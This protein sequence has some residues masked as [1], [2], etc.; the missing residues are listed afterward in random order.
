MNHLI[1]A[2]KEDKGLD[3]PLVLMVTVCLWVWRVEDDVVFAWFAL[4][5][6]LIG[7]ASVVAHAIVNWRHNVWKRQ[8]GFGE[9]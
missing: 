7:I 6:M 2:I 5:F 8:N 9:S 4:F 1:K 3:G